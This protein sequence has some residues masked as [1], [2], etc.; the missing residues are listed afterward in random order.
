MLLLKGGKI[1]AMKNEFSRHSGLFLKGTPKSWL[2]SRKIFP[3]VL[4]IGVK[5]KAMKNEFYKF[6]PRILG[7]NNQEVKW[8]GDP[9]PAGDQLECIWAQV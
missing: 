1:V 3:M 6:D 4:M 5:I 2:I 8:L 9:R 7:R